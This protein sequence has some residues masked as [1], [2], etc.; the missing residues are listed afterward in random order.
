[1]TRFP[2]TGARVVEPITRHPNVAAILCGHAHTPAAAT[3]AGRPLLVAP[4]VTSTVRPLWETGDGTDDP[5]DYERSPST[6]STTR[7]V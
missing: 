5:V 7:D 4:G 3:F 6:Y 1:M 2:A